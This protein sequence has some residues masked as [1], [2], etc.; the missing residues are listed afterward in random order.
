[1]ET[2]LRVAGGAAE[3]NGKLCLDSKRKKSEVE[4]NGEGK[5]WKEARR[6]QTVYGLTIPEDIEN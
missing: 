5:K 3:D 1:M 2:L 6:T 4:G